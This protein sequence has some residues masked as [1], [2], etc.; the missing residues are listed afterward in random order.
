MHCIPTA[1]FA[2]RLLDR[3]MIANGQDFKTRV[4]ICLVCNLK[5]YS[6]NKVMQLYL[7]LAQYIERKV[8]QLINSLFRVKFE[9]VPGIP[10]AAT[11]HI[12]KCE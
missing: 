4:H 5:I 7:L 12:K 2:I 6:K 10:P 9:L 1:I 3:H 8:I 11:M